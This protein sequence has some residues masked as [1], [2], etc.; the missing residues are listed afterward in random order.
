MF[1]H[2]EGST[3]M[4]MGCMFLA[5]V[6]AFLFGFD[7]GWWGTILGSPKFLSD[8]GSCVD[9]DGVSTC[10]LSTQ[11]LSVGTA[12]QS[13]GIMIGCLIAI[14]LNDLIGR[15][16]S[17]VTTG[18]ISIVGVLIEAT[19]ATGGSGRFSQFV[20]GK[21]IASIAMGL[22]VNIV[23][24]YLSETSTASARGFAVSI[25]QN[26]QILGL[27]LAAGIVYASA[28]STT[29]S[30][31]LIPICL[32]IIAPTIMVLASPI[33]PESPRWLMWKGR[34]NDAIAAATKLFA[35]P[36]NNFDA[37]KCVDEIQ[38]AIDAERQSKDASRWAD[39][40]HGPDLRRLLIAVG[41]QSLQQA[42]GSSYMNSY[43]VSFLQSTGVTDVFPVIMGLYALY[44]VAVLSGHVLP[45][46]VGRRPILMWTSA[47]CGCCLLVVSAL[48][49]GFKTPS[50]ATSKSSIALIFLWYISF[51]IQSPLIWITT[52][53]SAPTRN[54]EKVQAIACFFGF[55]VSLLITS[56]SPYIQNVGYGNLG[57]RIGFIWSA[58]AFVT[59]VW[60]FFTVPEMKGFSIEQLDFLYN[61]KVA[62]R[63]FKGYRFDTEAGIVV[64]S[65]TDDVIVQKKDAGAVETV[66]SIDEQGT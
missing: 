50:D 21:V 26:I 58:F 2:L 12:V 37:S 7:N 55:G 11:Q 61:N 39:L 18:A 57:G 34:R 32:Q 13:G 27:I 38:L 53:E 4:G 41:I 66:K 43:I 63:K 17:L 65:D 19:S 15:K 56:V 62:T 28:K 31:Y 51:G 54:R 64:D 40:M 8:Y 20:V 22:A 10:N 29:S 42:Q 36:T 16:L 23:P 48:V 24:I 14:Y 49:V 46:T 25:Y 3:P 9:V 59:L 52:A 6:G 60:V 44:Y 33:L 1:T 35:T 47:F 45:D 5:S 30:A